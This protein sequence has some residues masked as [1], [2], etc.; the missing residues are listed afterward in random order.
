MLGAQSCHLLHIHQDLS[1]SSLALRSAHLE[2]GQT[3]NK[4]DDEINTIGRNF[5]Y[6]FSPIAIFVVYSFGS[7]QLLTQLGLFVSAGGS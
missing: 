4:I 2:T 7:P 1:V 3:E 5:L 6:F